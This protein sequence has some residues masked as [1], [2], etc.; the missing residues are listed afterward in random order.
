MTPEEIAQDY[1]DRVT[2]K[3]VAW[4]NGDADLKAVLPG[5]HVNPHGAKDKLFVIFNDGTTVTL[6]LTVLD[7]T[8]LPE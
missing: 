7:V 2:H 8:N 1:S 5:K 6:R 3:V 4:L